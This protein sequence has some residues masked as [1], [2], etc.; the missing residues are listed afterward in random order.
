VRNEVERE[1][2][3]GCSR[4]CQPL[5]ARSSCPLML[6]HRNKGLFGI[7]YVRIIVF[8]WIFMIFARA[9]SFGT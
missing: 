3:S 6:T 2:L 7:K 1:R 5:A 8:F 4:H 9:I